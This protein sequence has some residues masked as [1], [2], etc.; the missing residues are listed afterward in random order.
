MATSRV[1]TSSILQGFPK[2]RSLLSGNPAF[3]PTDYESI[4]T[5]TVGSGGQSTISFSSIPSTYQH[6]QLRFAGSVSAVGN[7]RIRFNSD[8]GSNYAWHQLYG[9]GASL[10]VGGGASQ[11]SMVLAYDN[12]A[13]ALF[14]AP[15]V[16]DIFD[17]SNSNKNKTIRTITATDQN[18]ND[19]L[20]ILRSGLWMN[21]S[22]ITSISIFLDSGSFN[23]YSRFALYGTK[24]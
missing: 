24:G 12:K 11:S 18:N 23:Q 16:T 5:V 9:T 19:G 22:A 20:V 1:S 2:S 14:P 10:V 7:F 8:T 3:I 21:T 13:D 4:A 15:G 6:L 17:Y